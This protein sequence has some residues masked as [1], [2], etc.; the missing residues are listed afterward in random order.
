VAYG[1]KRGDV[2]YLL[3]VRDFL[4]LKNTPRF[5]AMVTCFNGRVDSRSSC[6]TSNFQAAGTPPLSTTTKMTCGHAG[7]VSEI[8][9]AFIERKN[10]KDVYQ[11][12]RRFPSDT[13]AAATVNKTVEFNNSRVVVF[14][15]N[16]Q[17]IVIEP[18]E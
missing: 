3:N 7:Q 2:A 14:E 4:E 8:E 15:D 11:F 12:T 13:P 16:F 18:P 6:S 17:T 10:D 5:R 1:S 9:C